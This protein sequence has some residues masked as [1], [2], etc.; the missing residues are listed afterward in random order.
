MKNAKD[1]T[2]DSFKQKS[3]PTNRL[4]QKGKKETSFFQELCMTNVRIDVF[5]RTF[6][7]QKKFMWNL[8]L[9]DT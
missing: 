4:R 2:L 8:D 3:K 9:Q 7:K 5:N 1:D 6:D